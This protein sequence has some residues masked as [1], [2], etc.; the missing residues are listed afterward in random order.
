M[1]L[2]TCE[3]L[4]AIYESNGDTENAAIMKARIEKKMRLPKYAKSAPKP[5]PKEVKKDEKPEG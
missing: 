3:K 1:T 2:E 5:K 4:L